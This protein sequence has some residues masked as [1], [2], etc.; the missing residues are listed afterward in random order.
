MDQ[1]QPVL[2]KNAERHANVF[3]RVFF[4]WVACFGNDFPGLNASEGGL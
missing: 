2:A 3:S 1:A 4:W